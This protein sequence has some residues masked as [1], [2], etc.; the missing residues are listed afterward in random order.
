[1]KPSLASVACSLFVATAF[2]SSAWAAPPTAEEITNSLGMKFK[3]IAPGEFLMGASAAEIDE[4]K[5]Q[6]TRSRKGDTSESVFHDAMLALAESEGPPHRVTISQ[7]FWLG[8]YEV[9]QNEFQQVMGFNPSVHAATGNRRKVMAGIDTR[10]HPVENLAWDDAAEFC[11]QLSSLEAEVAAGRT[12]RLPT[13]AEWEYAYRAGT[14]TKFYWGDVMNKP[15]RERVEYPAYD[16]SVKFHTEPVG[17]LEPNPW[18]LYDMHGNVR[19][20]C[21]DW[22]DAKT[23]SAA[24][25]RDPTGPAAGNERVVRSQINYFFPPFMRSAA[26]NRFAPA[27]VNLYN[28]FRVVCNVRAVA[29]PAAVAKV[30]AAPP[31]T[32]ALRRQKGLIRHGT[33]LILSEEADFT[34]FTTTLQRLRVACINAGREVDDAKKQL[35]RVAA[36]KAGALQAR[37]DARNVMRYSETWREHRYGI[38]SRNMADDALTLVSLSREDVESWLADAQADFEEAV[39]RYAAQCKSLRETYDRLQAKQRELAADAPLKAAIAAA[40]SAGK[41]NYRLGL[42]SNF[43]AAVK[44]LE[45]E[46]SLLKQFQS[47]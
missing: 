7:G 46:E 12:Y 4:R 10:R 36:A 26:R 24:A 25:V 20:W 28:G 31:E 47:R 5:A 16:A 34:R 15:I 42:S 11:R 9:T 43:A 27:V 35:Q 41:T 17:T 37:T 19:E 44:K 45:H 6:I 13:E 1:M 8:T 3:A 29:P 23:Y 33:L 21:A 40:G 2:V 38:I 14:T 32:E 39:S 22:Y 18:G 30:V